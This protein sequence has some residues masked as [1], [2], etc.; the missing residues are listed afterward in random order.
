MSLNIEDKKAVVAEVSAQLAEAQTLV[1]AEY[2][3]IE[4]S[5]MTKLRAQARENGVYLRVLKNTLVRRAVEGTPFAGLADQMVGP[6]VYAVSADPVAAAKVLHQF[7]KAD[8]KIIVKA[9][10][11]DG[12]VLNAAQ[13]AELASIPSREELLSK[14]LYVMQ[15]P[16]AGFARA[17]AAL[18]EKQAEAA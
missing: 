5:S 12:Q 14:L 7:A 2:R 8:D 10:S 4:V 18:A 11:Y 15:A 17:L 9:G 16:V 3:G 13:V 6:L 1:I